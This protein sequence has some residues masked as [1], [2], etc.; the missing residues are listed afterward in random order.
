M[1]CEVVKESVLERV[2]ACWEQMNGTGLV[3]ATHFE[4]V[5]VPTGREDIITDSNSHTMLW[6]DRP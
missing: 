1:T 4:C 6:D 5:V 2:N 3:K